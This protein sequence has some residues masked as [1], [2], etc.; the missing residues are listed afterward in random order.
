M[1]QIYVTLWGS[2]CVC[3]CV[4]VYLVL[5]SHFLPF[6]IHLTNISPILIKMVDFKNLAWATSFATRASRKFICLPYRAS[7]FFFYWHTLHTH[8]TI[9]VQPEC[10]THVT[11][12]RKKGLTCL[13]GDILQPVDAAKDEG[14]MRHQHVV[15]HH[16]LQGLATM[17]RGASLSKTTEPTEDEACPQSQWQASKSKMELK[18]KSNM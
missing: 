5:L 9:P 4:R 3:V 16:H 15:H 14:L 13:V 11:E 12:V 8:E 18:T 17:A 1:L 6:K 7:G 10:V 2:W